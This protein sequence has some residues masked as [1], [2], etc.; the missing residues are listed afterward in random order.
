MMAR[1][2]HNPEFDWDF[3]TVPQKYVK[4]RSLTQS[5]GKGLGGSSMVSTSMDSLTLAHDVDVRE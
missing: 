3:K 2:M 5:R 4:D 1:A